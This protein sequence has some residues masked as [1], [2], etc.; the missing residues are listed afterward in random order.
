[1]VPFATS[2]LGCGTVVIP[3]F[4]GCRNWWWLPAT[5]TKIHPSASIFRIIVRLSMYVEIHT[6]DKTAKQVRTARYD[7]EALRLALVLGDGTEVATQA[8]LGTEA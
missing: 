1:M 4:V 5:R 3:G 2:F 8:G 6:Q 7:P